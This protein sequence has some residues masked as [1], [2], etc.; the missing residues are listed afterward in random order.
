V[1]LHHGTNILADRSPGTRRSGGGG[2]WECG[3]FYG[4]LGLAK[5]TD[6]RIWC[7][8]LT[9]KLQAEL[10]KKLGPLQ[11]EV[12]SIKAESASTE[13]HLAELNDKA[14]ALEKASSDVKAYADF[15]AE[16]AQ[17]T[18]A[19][20]TATAETGRQIGALAAI[21]AKWVVVPVGDAEGN[22]KA[23]KGDEK[24]VMD[25]GKA[26]EKAAHDTGVAVDKTT[27]WK[28]RCSA[29]DLKC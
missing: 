13:K 3:D 7:N 10:D 27:S 15:T 16:A 2:V 9:L 22:S 14:V 5:K 26:L 17:S 20:A 6:F 25:Y 24:A 21:K 18:S 4:L 1:E 19:L 28:S 11:D 29:L 12:A 8:G 23:G